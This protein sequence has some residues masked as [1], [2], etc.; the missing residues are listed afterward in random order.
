MA[1]LG[2]SRLDGFET[3]DETCARCGSRG[4]VIR[5]RAA[6]PA[7]VAKG[8]VSGN[9]GCE[10]HTGSIDCAL[11][12]GGGDVMDSTTLVDRLRQLLQTGD[13]LCD[14]CLALVCKATLTEI[15]EI[16]TALVSDDASFQRAST[17]ATCRRT[18]PTLVY[19]T[20]CAHCS[21]PFV[22]GDP[23]VV[24]GDERLHVHCLRALLTDE[25]IQ[26]SRTLS[27]RSRELIEQSRRRLRDGRRWQPL[28]P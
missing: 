4:R 19:R 9:T 27:R 16:T 6:D 8:A 17:C 7:C 18:V 5:V 26:L 22:E 14:A 28:D 11:P 3:A 1:T 24:M 20:K 21:Q 10:P 2:L 15:H 12:R 23:G 25:T 13:A